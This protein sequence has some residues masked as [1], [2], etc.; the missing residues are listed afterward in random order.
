MQKIVST[1]CS[2]S[3]CSRLTMSIFPMPHSV[4][5]LERMRV[6]GRSLVARRYGEVA[7]G[8]ATD[9]GGDEHLT[10]LQQHLIRSVAGLVVL[11]ERLTRKH[12][13]RDRQHNGLLPLANA[14]RRI[15]ATLGL[16]RRTVT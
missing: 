12:Q 4:P 8:I 9:L 1:N 7:A 11:R 6:D 16:A 14:T 3:A 5:N 10:E 2:A 13:R 15:A